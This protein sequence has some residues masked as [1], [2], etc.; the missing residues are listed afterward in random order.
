M[1]ETEPSR[2]PMRAEQLRDFLHECVASG[3]AEQPARLA[4]AA[5]LLN[6]GVDRSKFAAMIACGAYESAAM[7]LLG[8]DLSFLL[9]RGANGVCIA[10]AVLADEDEDV[11]AQAA[12]PALA[13]IAAHVAAVLAGDGRAGVPL[14][15]SPDL[16]GARPH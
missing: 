2:G 3:P 15:R 16:A 14:R 8:P 11:T 7:L 6:G 5:Q 1:I 4:E 9:S 13:L 10:S 12:T